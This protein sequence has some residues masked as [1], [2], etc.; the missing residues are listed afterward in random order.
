MPDLQSNRLRDVEWSSRDGKGRSNVK[1]A[2]AARGCQSRPRRGVAEELGGAGGP[3]PQGHR[4]EGRTLPSEEASQRAGEPRTE[5]VPVHLPPAVEASVN[6]AP[7]AVIEFVPART[8]RRRRLWILGCLVGGIG[9]G[10]MGVLLLPGG[11]GAVKLSPLSPVLSQPVL[12]IP[13]SQAHSSA[14]APTPV[15]QAASPGA[16]RIGRMMSPLAVP[17]QPPSQSPAPSDTPT[18]GPSPT[19]TATPTPTP[20]HRRPRPRPP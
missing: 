9:I 12:G 6:S 15:G 8:V 4:P 19:V 16:S 14:H 7:P 2:D 3:G 20:S 1:V 17:T 13:T 5:L 10:A 18:P 11:R